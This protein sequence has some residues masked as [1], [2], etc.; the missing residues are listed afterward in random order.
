VLDDLVV[1]HEDVGAEDDLP[2]PLH[3]F[4]WRTCLRRIVLLTRAESRPL[5][6]AGRNHSEIYRGKDAYRFL[7]EV[8]CGLRSHL[9]GETEVMGQFRDFCAGTKF[10]P[11]SWGWF[12]RQITA[13]LMLDAKRVRHRH[14]E[15]LGSQSYGGL[16]RQQLKGIPS[17]AL[18]GSGQL[19]REIVP[20]LIGKSHLTLFCRNRLHAQ[21]IVD[22]F[23]QIHLDQ[24]TMADAGH[25]NGET[26]LVIVASLRAR[27]IEKWIGLQTRCFVKALDL[28]GEAATDPIRISF[29]SVRLFQLFAAVK[30]D[31]HRFASQVEAA[32]AEIGLA[33]ERQADQAQFR[34]F[35]WEDLC[36]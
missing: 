27:E 11:T 6:A 26:A 12:L 15:G 5:L 31:Q 13:N 16:V 22:E 35:G 14:L 32:R 2:T 3:I 36:A 23:P 24:F 29:P 10:P 25:G 28:R 17:V 18:V 21:P 20:W 1:V 30:D 7:L 34:P 9:I 4:H 33:A 19:A 8:V